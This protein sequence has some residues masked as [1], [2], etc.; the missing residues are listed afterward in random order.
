MFTPEDKKEIDKTIKRHLSIFVKLIN[1]KARLSSSYLV[2]KS[3]KI[4]AFNT[5]NN[6]HIFSYWSFQTFV[7]SWILSLIYLVVM[8]FIVGYIDL[9]KSILWQ[10]VILFIYYIFIFYIV[11]AEKTSFLINEVFVVLAIILVIILIVINVGVVMSAGIIVSAVIGTVVFVIVYGM[12]SLIKSLTES[13]KDDRRMRSY[14]F[15][16]LIVVTIVI[17][18]IFPRDSSLTENIFQL[19]PKLKNISQKGIGSLFVVFLFIMPMSNA[20][21]DSLSLSVSRYE[22]QK[23]LSKKTYSFPFFLKVSLLDFFYALVL[24]LFVLG[25]LCGGAYLFQNTGGTFQVSDIDIYIYINSIKKAILDD[26]SFSFLFTG[27]TNTMITLMVSTTLLPTIIHFVTV[28]LNTIWAFLANGIQLLGL[29]F[30]GNG[31]FFS[32][33]VTVMFLL[34]L[35]LLFFIIFVS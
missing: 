9:D 23:L 14:G 12:E 10:F 35:L 7:R 30:R 34:F 16:I 20:L 22:F 17:M 13:L 19:L 4:F 24:K 5:K 18:V 11:I 29:F 32:A 6:K 3:D 28:L 27:S 21:V 2:K 25:A 8:L 33:V 1:R 26:G 31:I 15:E